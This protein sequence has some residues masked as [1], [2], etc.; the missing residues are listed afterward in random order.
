MLPEGEVSAR[1]IEPGTYYLLSVNERHH[2]EYAVAGQEDK[3]HV[4]V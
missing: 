1:S 2:R 3:A 4:T